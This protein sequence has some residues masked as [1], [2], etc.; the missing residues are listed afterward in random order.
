MVKT[1]TTTEAKKSFSGMLKTIQKPGS[2]FVITDRGQPKGVFVSFQEFEGLMETLDIM[3][4][5]VLSR[6][7]KR[8]IQMAKDGTL[9]TIDFDT[10]KKSLAL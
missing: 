9:D 7:L 8:D 6:G 1:L 5:P 3:S 2:Y 4:D 10:F